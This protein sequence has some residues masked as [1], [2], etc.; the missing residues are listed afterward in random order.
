MRFRQR[1]FARS[2]RRVDRVD[3]EESDIDHITTQGEI[4]QWAFESVA[5]SSH[6]ATGHDHLNVGR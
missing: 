6:L 5:R 4:G 3:T 1:R 2:V